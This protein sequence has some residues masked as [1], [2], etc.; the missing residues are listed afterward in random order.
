MKEDV[1]R[2]PRLPS[3]LGSPLARRMHDSC[4]ALKGPSRDKEFAAGTG[5]ST[6]LHF[7]PHQVKMKEYEQLSKHPNQTSRLEQEEEGRVQ[8]P[9]SSQL[10]DFHPRMSSHVSS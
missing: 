4:G 3:P 5:L 6:R 7:L 2:Q 9:L 1:R 8:S 10:R